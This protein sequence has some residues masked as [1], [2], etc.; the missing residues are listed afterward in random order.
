MKQIL[1]LILVGVSSFFAGKYLFPPQPEIKEVTKTVTIEKIVEKRNVVKTVKVT[2]KPD[3]TKVTETTEKDK[4]I[5]IDN[6]DTRTATKTEVKTTKI[7]LGM[8][9]LKD[10]DNFKNT[11]FGA[12]VTVPLFGNIKAQAIGT[13]GKQIGVG[14]A[15]EF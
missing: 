10:L 9:A 2:E 12:T 14:L 5:I 1:T 6:T 3:G 15:W 11:E 4:S 8:L 13:T 7:T